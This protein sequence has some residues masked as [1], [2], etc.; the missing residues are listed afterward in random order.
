MSVASALLACAAGVLAAAQAPSY[1]TW[2]AG[3]LSDPS[4]FPIAVWLQ[5]PARAPD[6]QAAGFNL[7]IGLWEGPTEDQLATLAK[8]HMKVIC[9][10]SD[11]GLAHRDDPTIV[12]WHQQDEPDNAQPVTDANGQQGWGP[13]VPPADVVATYERLKKNDPTRPVMLNLGQGIANDDWYGRGN[14]AS[15][16]D[17]ATYIKGGDII[18]YDVYPVVGIDKPDGENYLWYIAKGLDRLAKW[19]DGKRIIWNV[20]ECTH[21]G[22]PDKKATPDQVRAEVWMSLIHGSRGIVYFVHQF[23]PRFI[24]AALLED[25]EMLAMVT[26]TNGEIRDLAPVLNSPT[27]PDLATVKSSTADVPIDIMAK[28]YE[29]ATYVF[30]V[31]MRN[32]SAK[33]TLTVPG[34]QDGAKVDVIGEGRALTIKGGSFEDDFAPYG[35]HLYRVG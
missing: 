11:V 32:A 33:G 35:V 17:Y 8:N 22:N 12:G 27:I 19:N 2:S 4:Y 31:G 26:R 10:Q 3:P 29:G 20:V 7:Y 9:D 14:G 15:L 24:E 6:F 30:A 13:C 18:S 21:I 23:E 1:S 25:P 5:E 16:D 34:A 28:R